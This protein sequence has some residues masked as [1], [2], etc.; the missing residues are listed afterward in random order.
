VGSVFSP[1]YAWARGRTGDGTADPLDFCSI[2]V[3]LYGEAAKRW[4]MTERRRGAVDRGPDHYRIGPSSLR[5]TGRSLLI[6]IDETAAPLPRPVRGRVRVTPKAIT[7]REFQIDTG[8]RHRWWP[9]APTAEV[10][11]AMEQPWLAWAG[12]GYLDRNMGDEPLEAGFQEWDWSRAPLAD[13]GTAILYDTFRRDGSDHA[14]ALKVGAD[15]VVETFDSP[16]LAELPGTRIWRIRRR[17]RSDAGTPATVAETLEDTPFYA[18]SLVDTTLQGQAVR[19]V[20][21][22]LSLDRFRAPWVRLLL[23]FRMPRT[24]G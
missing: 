17:T 3:A 11:V 16:P 6:D 22:S 19:Q 5:W 2:N 10:D 9:I 1:Y 15:G 18:R 24:L 8:G 13:G 21:E 23:P 12:T 7:E 4:T 20:H 14:L